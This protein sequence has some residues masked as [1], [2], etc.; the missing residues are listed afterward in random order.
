MVESRAVRQVKMPGKKLFIFTMTLVLGVLFFSYP[1]SYSIDTKEGLD[2]GKS[3]NDNLTGQAKLQS[4]KS[5][6]EERLSVL[7]ADIKKE[8]EQLTKLKKEV[9][10]AKRELDQKRQESLDKIVKIFES[11]PAEDAARRIEKLDENNS[12]L[13]LSSLKPKI[14]GKILAQIEVDMAASLSKKMIAK[15]RASQEKSSR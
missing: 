11:M 9:E 6:E 13:I 4:M 2:A 5:I 7:K 8:M 14:A 15:S 1:D 10:D 12:V 3:P